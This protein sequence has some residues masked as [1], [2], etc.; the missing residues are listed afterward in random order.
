MK[1]NS[2][3]TKKSDEI[4]HVITRNKKARYDYEI[5]ETLEAGIALTGSEVKSM[6]ENNAVI[7]GA[8]ARERN[9]E[10]FLEGLE[11]LPY[12]HASISIS[13]Q[14]KRQRKLLMHRQQ[15]DKW[16]H[17]MN[18]KHLTIVALKA[19]FKDGLVKIEVA[20]GK[21]KKH[22]DKRE[23]LKKKDT[24]RGLDRLRKLGS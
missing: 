5:I 14:P 23:D 22:H 9:G 6:R 24:Q 19:Y 10:F 15:I 7:T 16:M 3:K 2:K 21:G 13:H 4:E 18:T 8:F 20:L 1:K 12:S 11:I 17:Q